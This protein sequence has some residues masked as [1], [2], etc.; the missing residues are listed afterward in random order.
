MHQF[1]LQYEQTLIRVYLFEKEERKSHFE[2][3]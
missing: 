2:A 1:F 3:D